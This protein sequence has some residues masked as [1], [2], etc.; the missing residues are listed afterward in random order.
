MG[1]IK[2]KEARRIETARASDEELCFPESKSSPGARG[3][4]IIAALPIIVRQL[5]KMPPSAILGQLSFVSAKDRKVAE[6]QAFPSNFR[7]TAD[8]GNGR[9]R[10]RPALE[11]DDLV[12]AAER[13]GTAFAGRGFDL[14][15]T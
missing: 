10:P 6:R 14:I 11:Y 9:A 4:D 2:R 3:A 13:A 7:Q 1:R 12:Y 15:T 8:A 5:Q